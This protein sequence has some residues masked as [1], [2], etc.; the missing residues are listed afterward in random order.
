MSKN[1]PYPLTIIEDRYS[2]TYSDGRFLAFNL[3]SN[4]VSELPVDADDI[5]CK[6]FWDGLDEDFPIEDYV[7]GKGN[8]PDAALQDLI[9]KIKEED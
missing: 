9:E 7:I 8:S 2:G 5:S 4:K 6:R 3:Y 1:I